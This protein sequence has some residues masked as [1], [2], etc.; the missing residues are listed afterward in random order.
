LKNKDTLKEVFKIIK[1]VIP[2]TCINDN[3]FQKII[4]IQET[5]EIETRNIQ[6][7]DVYDPRNIHCFILPNSKK[8]N[9]V[10]I[11]RIIKRIPISPIEEFHLEPYK[12]IEII[13][14][15]TFE[16]WDKEL[17]NVKWY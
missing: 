16:E 17:K 9:K 2:T 12:I 5:K 3:E 14:E 8:E 1:K 15:Y 13:K 10:K 6:E 7:I 4:P 11:L